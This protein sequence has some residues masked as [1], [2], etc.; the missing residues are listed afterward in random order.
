VG[1]ANATTA[2]QSLEQVA[3]GFSEAE[4]RAL[5]PVSVGPAIPRQANAGSTA[6]NGAELA[7]AARLRVLALWGVLLLGVTVLG[8][9]VWRLVRPSHS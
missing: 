4:L 7:H 2:A 8:F 5:E 1:R 6:D 3:P 9:M